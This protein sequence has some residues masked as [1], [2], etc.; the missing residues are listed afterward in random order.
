MQKIKDL[1]PLGILVLIGFL[2]LSYKLSSNPPGIYADE[3]ATGINAYSILR[4]G[5]DEY[6]KSFPV[7]FRF[8]GS[9]S[10]PLHVYSTILPVFIFGLNETSVRVISVVCAS[11]MILVMYWYFKNSGLVEKRVVPFILLLFI[12][13]PWNFF[14]SRTGYELYLG[15]F[16]F[17]LAS[18]FL[19]LGVSSKKLLIPGLAVLSLSTYGSYPQIYS[20]PIFLLGFVFFFLKFL[21]R[22]FLLAGILLALIIQIPHILLLGTNSSASK[23]DLFYISEISNNASKIPLPQLLSFP[24]SLI[25]S[26]TARIVN[27]FSPNSLFFLPDPDPQRSMPEVSVFY[28]WM[29][30]PYLAG[31]YTLFAKPKD[32]FVRFLAILTIATVIPPALTHDPFSTQR[33]L[34]LLLPLFLITGIGMSLIYEKI[35]IKKFLFV[36]SLLFIISAVLLWRSYFVLLPA[37]R[38]I[39]WGYG[40]KDLAKYISQN[41]DK[42]FV[43]EQILGKPAYVELAFYLKTDPSILQNSVD[44]AIKGDYY[45]LIKFNPDLSFSNIETR[46][47]VWEKDIY[48]KQVLVGDELAISK[49]QAQE[50]YLKEVF[51]ITDP[52]G[53]PIFIGYETDPE[54]KC[55]KTSYS[56]VFCKN[57][58]LHKIK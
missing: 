55:A 51:R 34:P 41:S 46:T 36:Y 27:Y 40:Y 42:K 25:Y 11:L 57:L 3:A 8:F 35:G 50:H 13:T 15:F 10:P 16:L 23:G 28:N 17:S 56:S 53:Y 12:I 31:I 47:I 43:V 38:A 52:R 24:S 32:K 48:K 14:F 2:V 5:K 29:V 1:L 39:T 9:Y 18:L 33:A 58:D 37:E 7:A 30:I 19:W 6:G 44:P 45:N 20:V 26:T 22:K 54:K 49:E 4:T 21:D